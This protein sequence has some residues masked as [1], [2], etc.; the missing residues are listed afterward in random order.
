MRHIREA[1]QG[2]VHFEHVT[3]GDDTIGGVGA[4][5]K[6]VD[7]AER[8]APQTTRHG[9]R[10]KHCQRVSTARLGV[11]ERILEALEGGVGGDGVG[12]VLYALFFEPVELETANEEPKQSARGIDSKAVVC[13]ERILE[14][15][16][17]GVGGNGVGHVLCPLWVEVVACEAA[18]EG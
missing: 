13:N 6:F 3:D 18:N 7:P 8:V 16:E 2:A 9:A 11:R 5:A 17:G 1:R 4:P 15:L 12:H 14:I 10:R